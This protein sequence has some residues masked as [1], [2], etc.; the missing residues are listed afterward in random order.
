MNN[1][2]PTALRQDDVAA[3]DNLAPIAHSVDATDFGRT[4]F[5][6]TATGVRQERYLREHGDQLRGYLLTR[7]RSVERAT[8]CYQDVAGW[9]SRQK[10]EDLAQAPSIQA[11]YY[12]AAKRF[13]Q[14][15]LEELGQVP[16]L[17]EVPWIVCGPDAPAGYEALLDEV[18][19]GLSSSE[20]ELLELR[21]SRRLRVP[22]VAYVLGLEEDA[23][24]LR[25]ETALGLVRMLRN[26]FIGDTSSLAQ[27]VHDAFQV[28]PEELREAYRAR[29]RIPLKLSPKTQLDER[30]EIVECVGGGAFAWVYRA[31][32]LRVPGHNVAIKV[33][34]RPARTAP[35]REGALRELSVIASAFHPNL[36]QLKE[37]GWYQ[38]RL[39]FVMPWYEGQTLEARLLE[40]ALT[41]NEAA[42]LCASLS[43]AAEALHRVGVV[44]RD[45]KPENVFLAEIGPGEPSLPVLLDLGVASPEGDL[46]LAGTPLYF[47]PE[48]AKLILEED[49]TVGVSSKVDVFALALTCAHAVA[50][51]P[52][53]PDSGMDVFLRDR[54]ERPPKVPGQVPRRLRKTLQQALSVNAAERPSAV[55]FASMLEAAAGKQRT[56]PVG[57][58]F[59]KVV[60][61]LCLA[62]AALSLMAVRATREQ[63]LYL[64]ARARMLEEEL[65]RS[66]A[67][68]E[69]VQP[70]QPSAPE[71]RPGDAA[72]SETPIAEDD[73]VNQDI[74]TTSSNR[75]SETRIQNVRSGTASGSAPEEANPTVDGSLENNAAGPT[76]EPQSEDALD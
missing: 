44:H 52:A 47:A 67:Q 73:S 13:A 34:H 25:I 12:R 68:W 6:A 40:G 60:A 33:L 14:A 61:L 74:E 31:R 51:L 28:E 72:P 65:E 76:S 29:R 24:L 35:A 71:F 50:G 10:R 62:I 45:I 32:D 8:D 48:M 26:D 70:A 17:D 55:E 66:D 43:R 57:S 63:S 18:R 9:L 21:Y 1:I 15:M 36:V 23:V 75:R 41:P 49:E 2:A 54:A 11:S 30:F 20:L 37:H 42:L 7:L 27:V 64:D 38:E 46:A 58:G 22:E 19:R 53:Q 4:G 5:F 59:A 3:F 16:S 39:W 69:V 56:S